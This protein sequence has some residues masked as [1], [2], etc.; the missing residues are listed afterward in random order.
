MKKNNKI[1][2]IILA[3]IVLILC[4][5]IGFLIGKFLYEKYAENKNLEIKDINYLI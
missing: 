1:R 2:D 3:T 5:V 4:F